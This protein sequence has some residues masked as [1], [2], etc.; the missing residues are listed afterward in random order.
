[1]NAITLALVNQ[2]GGVG[3][4]TTAVNLAAAFAERGVSVLLVD[5]DSQASAS[6]SL[7]YDREN[8]EDEVNAAD[9]ILGGRPAEGAVRATEID[10]LDVILGSGA[11]ADADLTLAP[12]RGRESRLRDALLPLRRNYHLIVLDCPPSLS[13][14]SVNALTAADRFIVPVTPQ[15]LALEGIASLLASVERI[16]EGVGGVARLLGI[17]LTMVDRRLRVTTDI[18]TLLRE[19]YGEQVFETEIPVN[20]RLQ[21]APSF[22]KSIL[23]Y[24]GRASG[25]IAYRMLAAEIG[26]MIEAG[27][28]AHKMK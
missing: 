27:E 4:T 22:G 9:V 5:V 19:H 11:L 18:T 2:K 14:L 15:Y 8:I 17:L 20:V 7:G 23:E 6:L 13:L 24:D 26:R 28:L 3:K 21:E 10:G 12:K 1:M 25:A 16:R